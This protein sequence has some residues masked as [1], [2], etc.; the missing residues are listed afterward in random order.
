MPRPPREPFWYARQPFFH[1][2]ML[3]VGLLLLQV[4]AAV[5]GLPVVEGAVVLLT[6]GWGGVLI[7][8]LAIIVVG[9]PHGN[10]RSLY[11]VTAFT[12][13]GWPFVLSLVVGGLGPLFLEY[14]LAMREIQ[15]S[16]EQ[17]SGGAIAPAVVHATTLGLVAGWLVVVVAFA[18]R[19]Q[20]LRR[21]RVPH[22]L[23]CGHELPEPVRAACPDCGARGT[24]SVAKSGT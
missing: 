10:A 24:R 5:I 1:G 12:G 2:C 15:E 11:A 18:I 9:G 13:S 3:F 14:S 8:W 7:A 4:P 22:C 21:Q 17:A 23:A 20:Q 19:I 6:M 16:L